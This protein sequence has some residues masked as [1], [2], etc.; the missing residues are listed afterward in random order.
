MFVEFSFSHD[1]SSESF[2]QEMPLV[3]DV[4][5]KIEQSQSTFNFYVLAVSPLLSP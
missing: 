2:L 3:S 1:L 4:L 5:K